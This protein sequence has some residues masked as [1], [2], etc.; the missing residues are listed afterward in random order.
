MFYK[1]CFKSVTREFK[2]HFAITRRNKL[3]YFYFLQVKVSV[4]SADGNGTEDSWG[5]ANCKCTSHSSNKVTQQSKHSTS[6]NCCCS[7]EV[8]VPG[9]V[10]QHVAPPVTSV[11]IDGS[12]SAS[13]DS[14]LA[15]KHYCS[16]CPPGP[17]TH[18]VYSPPGCHPHQ[19]AAFMEH[20]HCGC[21]PGYVDG[22]F[23][24]P[25]QQAPGRPVAVMA[26]HPPPPLLV[27]PVQPQHMQQHQVIT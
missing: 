6:Q 23:H 27:R 13:Q 18:H 19:P 1:G 15:S 20:A 25:H 26:A 24:F 14:K 9:M 2:K 5:S 4:P 3:L 10:Y 21:Q 16:S 7:R 8:H 17:H 22:H 11:M 12:K